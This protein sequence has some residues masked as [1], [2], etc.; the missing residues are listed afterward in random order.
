MVTVEPLGGA[1]GRAARAL[2]AEAQ[3]LAP[4]R[5]AAEAEL[6]FA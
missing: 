5:G 2:A 6:A 4:F 3:R 1:A